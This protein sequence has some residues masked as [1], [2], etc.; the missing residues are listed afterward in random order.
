MPRGIP[1]ALTSPQE[2]EQAVLSIPSREVVA[3]WLEAWPRLSAIAEGHAEIL[4]STLLEMAGHGDRTGFRAAWVFA[5]LVVEGAIALPAP[6]AACLALWH[7]TGHDGV[8]REMMRALLVLPW[9]SETLQDLVAWAVNVVHLDGRKP[10]VIHHAL[11]VMERALAAP[12][13]HPDGR[14]SVDMDAMREALVRLKQDGRNNPFVKKKAALL[15]AR[16]PLTQ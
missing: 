8:R 16:L 9:N 5:H 7:G 15:M 10:A 4:E 6:G 2:L 13:P 3:Q 14:R 1:P 12:P 11:K